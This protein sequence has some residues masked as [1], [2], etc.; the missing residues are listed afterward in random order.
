[1]FWALNILLA[2]ISSSLLA[3]LLVIYGR[4]A[5]QIRSKFAIGLI[6]F[7]ALF[8]VQNLAGMWIYMSMNDA[9][10]GANVAVPMLV[11][12]A[13]ETGA[14]GTLVAISWE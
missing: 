8:L 9:L 1:M 7:A 5:A 2:G 13:T 6:V 14:L 10:L 4:N 12:N 11:L 3:V